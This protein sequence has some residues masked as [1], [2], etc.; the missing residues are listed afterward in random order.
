MK[1]YLFITL[2][3]GIISLAM[4]F[5]SCDPVDPPITEN[6]VEVS[7]DITEPTTWTSDNI[8]VIKMSDF[9]IFSTLTIEAGTIIKFPPA[10]KN[11]SLLEGGKI[12][13]NGTNTNPIIFTSY[14]DD[15]YGG[16]T[17]QDG[18][19]TIPAVGD[20]EN[21][22]LNGESGSQFICCN[23][24]YGGNGTNPAPTLNLSSGAEAT[25]DKC[26]FAYNGGGIDG[27]FYVGV[28]NAKQASN[29]TVITNCTFYNNVLPLTLAAEINTDNSNTF[30]YSGN[31]N[32]YNGIFI[33][34]DIGKNTSWEETDVPYVITSDNMNVNSGYVLTLGNN[35]ILKFIED[36]SLTLVSGE[37]SLS[38]YNG[39]GIFYTSLKDDELLGDTNGDESLTSPASSDW[40]GIFLDQWKTVGYADW[41]NILYNNPNPG[42]K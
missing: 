19:S 33:S 17:N 4:F 23:F 38:N 9:G 37:S 11:I 22:D 40:T 7:S 10:Y 16:D 8:Y 28:I 14:K 18:G 12:L 6:I 41:P 34:G 39:S 30:S 35:V 1:N 32:T 15:N 2:I 21:I 42:V 36:A 24:L 29:N 20:W 31:T 25:I 13:A 26:T 3:I 27:N 5:T